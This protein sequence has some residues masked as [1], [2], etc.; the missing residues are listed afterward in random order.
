MAAQVR[1]DRTPEVHRA[2]RSCMQGKHAGNTDN[3]WP[4]FERLA[5]YCKIVV[6]HVAVWR[7]TIRPRE[8]NESVEVTGPEL[9]ETVSRALSQAEE[10]GWHS[11]GS[12]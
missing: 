11:P 5:Q 1:E 6:D 3:V 10:R 12:L 7:V 8:G 2:R 9:L 4:R